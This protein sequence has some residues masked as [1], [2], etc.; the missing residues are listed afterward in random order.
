MTGQIGWSRYWMAQEDHLIGVLECPAV[1]A[2]V[3]SIQTTL[4]EPD[5]VTVLEA[6]GADGVE[7]A[8]PVKGFPCHLGAK[9]GKK[10]VSS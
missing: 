2:V 7:G 5:N 3:G 8:I 9:M 1:D 10:S 6:A 4:R